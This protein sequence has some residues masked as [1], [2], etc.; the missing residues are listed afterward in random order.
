MG[1]R[2]LGCARQ[3]DDWEHLAGC[4]WVIK[5]QTEAGLESLSGGPVGVD[6]AKKDVVRLISVDS[7]CDGWKGF[8]AP[9]DANI[10]VAGDV[11][12]PSRVLA[13][14]RHNYR[15]AVGVLHNLE[16]R[17]AD[18]AALPSYVLDLHHAL[19]Q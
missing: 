9:I 15:F 4:P 5:G 3:P 19:C 7:D 10:G 14:P 18:E 16:Y 12:Q 13:E 2:G 8:P 17:P 11:Q 6:V 1:A